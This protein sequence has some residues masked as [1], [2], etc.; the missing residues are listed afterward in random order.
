MPHKIILA[1]WLPNVFLCVA[2]P[3]PSRC[4]GTRV[5]SI[6]RSD[7][8]SASLG[9]SECE[10]A[11]LRDEREWTICRSLLRRSSCYAERNERMMTSEDRKSLTGATVLGGW[12]AAS[13]AACVD[14]R[15]FVV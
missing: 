8:V 10:W 1:Y 11:I 13:R 14:V 3:L 12:T 5:R 6:E 2:L 4:A 7:V 15:L 9:D